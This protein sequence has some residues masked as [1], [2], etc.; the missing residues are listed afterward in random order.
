MGPSERWSHEETA[1]LDIEENRIVTNRFT[2]WVL[3]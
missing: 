3:P 2:L 1:F